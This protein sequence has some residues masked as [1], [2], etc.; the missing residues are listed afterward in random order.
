MR[1]K[2]YWGPGVGLRNGNV[3]ISKILQA[4]DFL[5]CLKSP[6]YLDPLKYPK[7]SVFC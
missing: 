3:Q 7:V 4:R 2:F 6:L 1:A 5:G